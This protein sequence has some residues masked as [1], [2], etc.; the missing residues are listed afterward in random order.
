MFLLNNIS[1]VPK[2]SAPIVLIKLSWQEVEREIPVCLLDYVPK[3]D[4]Q[5]VFQSLNHSIAARPPQRQSCMCQNVFS[6]VKYPCNWKYEQTY[7]YFLAPAS[8]LNKTTPFPSWYLDRYYFTK[9]W[10]RLP[11]IFISNVRVESSNKNLRTV[12]C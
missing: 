2:Y 1:C 11:E 9:L 4:E 5:F 12:V 6:F 3:R 10:E 8:K 7:M